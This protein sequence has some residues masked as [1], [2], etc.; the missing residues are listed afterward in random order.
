MAKDR[1]KETFKIKV[2]PNSRQGSSI[3][4]N[5]DGILTVHTTQS[6]VG[7]KANS[8]AI[9]L[10]AKH[11]NVPKSQLNIIRGHTSRIKIVEMTRQ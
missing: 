2:K 9:S 8:A 7:G 4:K 3:E 1:L 11:F 10:L 5:N 6:A